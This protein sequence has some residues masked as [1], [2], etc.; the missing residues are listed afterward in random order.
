MD[1][2]A[3]VSGYGGSGGAGV[4]ILRYPNSFTVQTTNLTL[5]P[6]GEQTTGTDKYIVITGSNGGSL[7]WT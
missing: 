1:G 5:N 2:G 3:N 7:Y 4:V 6:A